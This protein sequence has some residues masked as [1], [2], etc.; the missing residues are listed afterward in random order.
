MEEN[1]PSLTIG[2]SYKV[3]IALRTAKRARKIRSRCVIGLE[4]YYLNLS[5]AIKRGRCCQSAHGVE[6]AGR[7]SVKRTGRL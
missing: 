2:P 5:K 3:S 6:A 7:L 4:Y 1:A